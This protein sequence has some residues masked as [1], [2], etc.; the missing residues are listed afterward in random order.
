MLGGR[1]ATLTARDVMTERLIVLAEHDTLAHASQVFREKRITGAPV[2]N[3]A[4]CAVGI[5]SMTDIL[6][7]L[8][9]EFRDLVERADAPSGQHWT[10]LEFARSRPIA[11]GESVG[12]RMSRRLVTVSPDTLLLDVARVMCH[13][14]WHRVIVAGPDGRL[15]GIVTTMDI[16]SALVNASDEP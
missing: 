4:G 10:E 1:L 2:V 9:G 5:L 12:E 13:G 8:P 11:P 14:H 3:A 15:A 7:Q 6:S 16:L